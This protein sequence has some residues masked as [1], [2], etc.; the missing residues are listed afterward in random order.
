VAVDEGI[1]LLLIQLL[2]DTV[3]AAVALSDGS[4]EVARAQLVADDTYRVLA[5]ALDAQ[6]DVLA[7]EVARIVDGKVR[8]LKV[9][10]DD[11]DAGG[12]LP[13]A[14]RPGHRTSPHI[15]PATGLGVLHA[16]VKV[17]RR[18]GVGGGDSVR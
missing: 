16:G 3:L 2:T 1:A 17:E 14:R 12:G 15:F 4:G 11:D 9:L 18:K 5:S 10:V 13:S 8:L 6:P 7:R